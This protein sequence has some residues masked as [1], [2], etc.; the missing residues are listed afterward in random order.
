[1]LG[2]IGIKRDEGLALSSLLWAARALSLLSAG[3]LLLFLGGEESDWSRVTASQWVG[4]A[5][6]PVGILAGLLV[7]WRREAVGGALT[8]ASLA[9]FHTWQVAVGGWPPRGWAFAVFALPGFL[10][11]LYAA[12]ARETVEPGPAAG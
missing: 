4:F 6:F 5:F 1:M 9:A 11:L 12:L 10:F 3:L 2:N 8:V 7:A